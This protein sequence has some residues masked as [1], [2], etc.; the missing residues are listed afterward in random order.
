VNI[1]AAKHL[2][3][4][5]WPAVIDECR[6]V[7]G[8]EL[9]Y[10]AVIY[11]CLR[12]AGCPRTQ[13]GMNVKQWIDNPVSDLF[14]S[15]DLRKHAD[16]RGGF[17]PIPD[18]LLFSSGIEGDWRR[19]NYA[20]T[21]KFMICAIEVKAS[22]RS[23]ARLTPG[24]VRADIAKLAAHRDEVVHLGGNML[25]VMMVIDVAPESNERMRMDAITN[26]ARYAA[27]EGV[28]WFYASRESEQCAWPV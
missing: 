8:G 18:L 5:A 4:T 23:K 25:P 2:L 13:I 22:E 21:L 26:C 19:R 11:H 20:N 14:N 6:A 16:F 27:A 7:L 3:Q 9:H 17:E 28:A 24:E 10:Q 15:R 1:A 12:N